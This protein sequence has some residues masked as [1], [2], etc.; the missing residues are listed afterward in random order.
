LNQS[1]NIFANRRRHAL[2]LRRILLGKFNRQF[3]VAQA[4]DVLAQL[5]FVLGEDFDR[6][7]SP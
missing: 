4:T 6:P 7:R 5:R 2:R 3:A 1:G